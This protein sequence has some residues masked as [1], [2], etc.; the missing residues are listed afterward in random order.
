MLY[1]MNDEIVVEGPSLGM[2]YVCEKV[3]RDLPAWFGILQRNRDLQALLIYLRRR[4]MAEV[5]TCIWLSSIMSPSPYVAHWGTGMPAVPAAI[6][7]A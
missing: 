6:T 7:V 2:G 4:N 3:L 1:A 5:K